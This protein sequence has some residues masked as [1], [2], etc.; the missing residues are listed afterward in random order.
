MAET[1][2]Q[3]VVIQASCR[4]WHGGHD[5]CMNMIDGYPV[6]YWT[7]KK[8]AE[9]IPGAEVW[10]ALPEHD[11]EKSEEFERVL[12]SY[13]TGFY[14]G[15]SSSPLD[16]ILHVVRD[17]SD[18]DH[19]VRIDGIHML[20]DVDTCLERLHWAKSEKLDC[21][22]L[23]DDF[24]PQFSTDTYRVGAVR[25]LRARLKLPEEAIYCVH[26]KFYL[27]SH[28]DLYRCEYGSPPVLTE[29]YLKECRK[30]CKAIYDEPRLDV[31]EDKRI[32]SGD[33]MSF[34]YEIA[35]NYLDPT[36]DVLDLGCGEGFGCRMLASKVRTICGVDADNDSVL[37]A[38]T[39]TSDANVSFRCEDATQMSFPDAAFNA[40]V[41]MELLEHV[42][43]ATLLLSEVKRVLKPNG[44]AIFSTPQN[45]IGVTPVNWHHVREYS[46][47]EVTE[48]CGEFFSIVLVMGIKAGRIVIPG[49]SRGLNT[50][51]ICK[52]V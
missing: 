15:H 46:L 18:D 42:M 3:M 20:F 43:P 16:R 38:A 34:H 25:D 47:E 39:K 21:V 1:N 50:I 19:F 29:D 44:V 24:P 12:S 14:Y 26:P 36:M 9:N 31:H 41:C 5:Q 37:N 49:D 6:T 13:V 2:R 40:V 28:R 11:R 52:N 23:P 51:L 35:G 48:L 8:V 30:L 27:F 22:K 10:V 45:G 17:L 33:Q 7:V 32:W 4:A